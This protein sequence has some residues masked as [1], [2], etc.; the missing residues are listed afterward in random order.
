MLIYI[1][2][3]VLISLYGLYPYTKRNSRQSRRIFLY[4]S[5]ATMTLVLGLRGSKVGE[6]TEHYLDVFKYASDVKWTDMLHSTGLRTG[7]FTDQW[8]YTDTIENGFLALAKVIHWITDDGQF[9]LFFIAAVTCALF[10]I[11][12]YDNCERVVLPTY[13]FLCESMFMLAFNGA[14]QILA[15]AI[16]VQAYTF[17]KNEKWKK[18]IVV[19]LI[20]TLIHNVALVCFALFPI[21]LI[22]PKK[23]YRYFKYAIIASVASP[24]IIIAAQ[25]IITR[26]FPRYASYFSTNYWS[27][28]VGGTAIL[29][30][31]EFAL[32]LIAYRKK[33]KVENS[34]KLA[35]CG[36]IYLAC[37]LMGLQIVMFSRVGW[38]FRP[39]L[40]LFFPVCSSYFT[41]KTWLVVQGAL[42]VMMILL[43][44][45]YA[46][47]PS[48]LYSFYWQ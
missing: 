10:A 6:D 9:F 46:G 42:L 25:S 16:A 11:F 12:I 17:L 36:L 33:F 48:R 26:I 37:E 18:A 29:W 15:A 22:K 32:I 14:R 13:I 19:I 34:F 3:I 1:L 35:C 44:L 2:V 24:F 45:S 23:E 47:T 5:F 30:L 41:K 43:Y 27:N 7:Y 38:F 20:A 28:S 4:L 39:Y 21:M 8:G 40:I 31:V